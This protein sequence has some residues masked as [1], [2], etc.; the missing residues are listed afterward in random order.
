MAYAASGM[1]AS[2]LGLS[3]LASRASI[4]PSCVG[5]SMT[6]RPV[7]CFPRARRM[8]G[9]VYAVATTVVTEETKVCVLPSWAEFDIGKAAVYWKT[10]NGLPPSAGGKLTLFYNPEASRLAPN[11]EFGVAFNGGFNQPFMCGGEPRSMTRKGRGKAD[12]PLYTIKICIPKHAVSLIFSFTNGVDWDGPYKLQFEVPKGWRN[13]PISFFNEGLAAELSEE[14]AC[15]RA[16]FPDSN[17]VATRCAMIGNLSIEGGD[18]CNLDIVVGC[19]DPSSHLYNP[20]A[21]VDD[22]SCPLEP[23][24]SPV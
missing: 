8:A 3:N 11:P 17:I 19:T 6:F 13:K 1:A 10:V 21:D 14:G 15:E 20:L 4:S 5:D 22:G 24:E 9:K 23:D 2:T 18:R 7:G 12:P 16:I